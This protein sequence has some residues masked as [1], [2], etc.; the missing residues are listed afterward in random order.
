MRAVTAALLVSGLLAATAAAARADDGATI[1][2][3]PVVCGATNVVSN[4]VV[5]CGGVEDVPSLDPSLVPDVSNPA[6]RAAVGA[7]ATEQRTVPSGCLLHNE[8][9][10]Y[11]AGDWVRLA[12]KLVAESSPCS[13]FLISVPP[14][15]ADKTRFRPLE[16]DRLRAVGPQIVPLAEVHF[17]TWQ[18]WRLRE[19]KS[20]FEAGVEARRRLDA[21][22]YA[23]WALNEVPSSVRQGLPAT[24]ANLASFLDGLYVGDGTAP[25]SKGVVFIV[26]VGQNT[27]PLNVYKT[28]LRNWLMDGLFWGA[29]QRTVSFWA[30]EVYADTRFWGVEGVARDLRSEY[31]T[32]YLQH[33]IL[34]ARAGGDQNRAALDFLERT[35][36]PLANAA[37]RWDFGFGNTVVDS[38]QMTM[39]VAEQT[40]AMRDFVRTY[41]YGLRN[42]RLGFAWAQRN[43]VNPI[44]TGEFVSSTAA[45]L[46]RMGDGF[47]HAYG[48]RGGAPNDA[49]GPPGKRVWCDGAVDGAAF[50]DAWK[51]FRNW[52]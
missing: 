30:Q 51:D 46:E 41:A 52:P 20:W 9:V 27:S 25:P 39:F 22:G 7:A 21:A 6:A 36:L 24:R 48:Q 11:A 13:D 18:T 35:H 31:L 33:V 50:Y 32:D 1:P 4:N 44:P 8:A 26:G 38:V 17:S 15:V 19:G 29:M 10:F 47:R 40:Y 5:E 28:N 3:D 34:L 2:I 49:C 43:L 42:G 16:D 45:I 23:G 37:W 14:I 12:Q